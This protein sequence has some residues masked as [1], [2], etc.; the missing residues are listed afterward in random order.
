MAARLYAGYDVASGAATAVLF[1]LLWSVV[2]MVAWATRDRADGRSGR[3][4][5]KA[6]E[7]SEPAPTS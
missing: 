4:H 2:F 3:R 7:R 1:G 6:V 5:A